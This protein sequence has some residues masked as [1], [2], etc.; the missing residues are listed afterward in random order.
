MEWDRFLSAQIAQKKPSPPAIMPSNDEQ[1]IQQLYAQ[2]NGMSA[3]N[4]AANS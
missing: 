3:N 4:W 1:Q 2:V